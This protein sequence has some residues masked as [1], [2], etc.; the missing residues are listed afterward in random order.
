[1]LV[2]FVVEEVGYCDLIKIILDVGKLFMQDG[3]LVFF[4][5]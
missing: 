1:M 4:V 5:D 2:D 3:Y